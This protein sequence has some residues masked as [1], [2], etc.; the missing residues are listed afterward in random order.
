MRHPATGSTARLTQ[1]NLSWRSIHL[2]ARR[3]S[4]PR[5]TGLRESL[6]A[7]SSVLQAR[8]EARRHRHPGR[9]ATLRAPPRLPDSWLRQFH[10]H[11]GCR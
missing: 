4:Q 9:P 8:Q 6:P 1:S 5:P 3:K 11:R 7:L 10:A 2:P